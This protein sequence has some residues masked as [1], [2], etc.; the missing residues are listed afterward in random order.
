MRNPIFI[1]SFSLL[2]LA[3]SGKESSYVELAEES[4]T[5]P[6]EPMQEIEEVASAERPASTASPE[7]N[8]AEEAQISAGYF[9]RVRSGENLVVLADWAKTTPTELAELNGMDVQDTLFAGRKLGLKLEGEGIDSFEGAREDVLEARLERYLERRGGLYT[10]EGH[11]MRSGETVWGLAKANGQLP[12][13][14]V[15]AFNQDLNL[16]RLGI[17]DF[18][19]LPVLADTVQASVEPEA[20]VD[21]E[22]NVP[23]EGGSSL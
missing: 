15:S 17:G 1:L 5:P 16:D 23:E 18:I 4:P 22:L 2:S 14:V 12:M 20:E 8:S 6:Y 13:W 10:V 3:C 11:A 19:T 9:I 21:E 7:I